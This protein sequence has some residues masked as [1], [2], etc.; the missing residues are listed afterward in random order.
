MTFP[1]TGA[2]CLPLLGA[3]VL[4]LAGCAA[5]QATDWNLVSAR[6]QHRY[7]PTVVQ[8]ER[9]MVIITAGPTGMVVGTGPDVP[10]P[11]VQVVTQDGQLRLVSEQTL[12]A[13]RSGASTGVMVASTG[14][15]PQDAVMPS[16]PNR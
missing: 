5:P 16:A 12:A 15:P 4:V 1:R 11:A 14:A 6:D 7:M 13:I 2:T 8:D 3:A 10:A 9:P